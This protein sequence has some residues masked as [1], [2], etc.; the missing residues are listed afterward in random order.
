M[1]FLCQSQETYSAYLHQS[2]GTMRR[3]RTPRLRP[4]TPA[5]L[6]S[7]RLRAASA[8][9]RPRF[10][11]RGRRAGDKNDPE[12]DG[13]SHEGGRTTAP[14]TAGKGDSISGTSGGATWGT[15]TTDERHTQ[16]SAKGGSVLLDHGVLCDVRYLA[17]TGADPGGGGAGSGPDAASFVSRTERRDIGDP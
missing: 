4:P 11:W 12:P 16:R 8:P 17:I 13:N 6:P 3:I 7:C 9:E 15:Q 14:G 5:P 1:T 2:H 10:R